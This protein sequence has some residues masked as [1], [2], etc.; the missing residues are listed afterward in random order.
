MDKNTNILIK[1]KLQLLLK[2]KGI[3][4]NN[5]T[6][7]E[8]NKYIKKI[9]EKLIETTIYQLQL[10]GR[11]VIKEKD[12]KKAIQKQKKETESYEI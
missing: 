8:F 10:E 3:K 9:I 1:R 5:N 4:A 11:K 6:I 7:T 12:I 2:E